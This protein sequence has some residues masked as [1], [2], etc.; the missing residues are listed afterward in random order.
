ML[1]LRCEG[2]EG[3]KSTTFGLNY[4]S[5]EMPEMQFNFVFGGIR[6]HICQAAQL[7]GLVLSGILIYSVQLRG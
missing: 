3:L 7:P 2:E 6:V 4:D 1:E 5:P